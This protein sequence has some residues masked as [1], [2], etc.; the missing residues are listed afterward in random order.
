M[1]VAPGEA[2]GSDPK[3]GRAST[4]VPADQPG[5]PTP[6]EW[7]VAEMIADLGL[8]GR[9][10][11]ERCRRI[12][13]R[14]VRWATSEG[15]PLDRESI[16]DPAT[17]ER[18]CQVA[19]AGDR[20]RATFRSDL[21]RMGPLLT[22]VA[23]WEPRPAPMAVRKVAPPYTD[24]EVRHLRADVAHQPTPARRRGARALV[25]L[26]LGAGLDGRWVGRVEAS[27]VG[28]R[29]GVVEV[30]VGPPAPRSVVV[31]SEWEEEILELAATAGTQFL[32]GGHSQNKN[33]VST[34]A[35]RFV[36]PTD[37][38]RLSTPRLRST[39]LLGHLARGTRLPE[40]CQAAGF[41]GFTVLSDLLSFVPP[42]GRSE[43]DTMLRGRKP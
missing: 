32:I 17:V 11:D 30:R 36:R 3:R 4:N 31:E 8:G 28:R 33:R 18:F 39:W 22:R 35:K 15:L 12:L 16:L 1:R 23:P 29:R 7:F 27:D 37:H 10:V 24:A 21:R 41:D 13:F 25:A 42:L 19:L 38:P 34:L 26:G 5:P 9:S 6:V 20:S 14:L 2:D 40:L 43:A